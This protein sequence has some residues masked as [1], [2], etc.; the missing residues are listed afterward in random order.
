MRSRVY[1]SQLILLEVEV[2]TDPIKVGRFNTFS[3]IPC[4]VTETKHNDFKY[5]LDEPVV[6]EWHY[7]GLQDFSKGDHLRVYA[8][9]KGIEGLT[10]VYP[11]RIDKIDEQGKMISRHFC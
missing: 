9:P 8:T 3:S 1:E 5:M 4:I 6:V 11:R 7:S 2:I 10:V